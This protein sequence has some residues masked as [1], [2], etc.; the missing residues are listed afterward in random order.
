[1][2]RS[3]YLFRI[4]FVLFLKYK[5]AKW[6]EIIHF[7]EYKIVLKMFY[8]EYVLCNSQDDGC[9]TIRVPYLLA[10][11]NRSVPPS[12]CWPE[13]KS[14]SLQM[15][16]NSNWIF[17]ESKRKNREN[18]IN[19]RC[20]KMNSITKIHNQVSNKQFAF[21]SSQ[22]LNI[23]NGCHVNWILLKSSHCR[24]WKFSEILFINIP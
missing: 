23:H 20:S 8:V 9:P 11:T 6:K 13:A 24:L 19:W 22:F 1:M 21:R 3:L 12:K 2:P 17:Y 4:K 15:L 10:T 5:T 16:S 7:W 14:N 18:E